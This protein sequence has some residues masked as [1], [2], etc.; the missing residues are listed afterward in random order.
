MNPF[1]PYREMTYCTHKLLPYIYMPFSTPE[2]GELFKIVSKK[3]FITMHFCIFMNCFIHLFEFTCKRCKKCCN[4]RI[5]QKF[6]H[7]L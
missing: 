4:R 1:G 2:K 5:R 3:Q 7:L 6:C